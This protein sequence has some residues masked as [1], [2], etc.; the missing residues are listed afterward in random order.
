MPA[1]LGEMIPFVAMSASVS[2][3]FPWSCERCESMLGTIERIV[4]TTCANMQISR[5][6]Q[7]RHEIAP[8]RVT[9]ISDAVWVALQGDEFLWVDDRHFEDY[10][11]YYSGERIGIHA[12]EH[13]RWKIDLQV[14]GGLL[15][16]LSSENDSQ[17]VRQKT[18][19]PTNIYLK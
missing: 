17:P 11:S 9:Y 15:I 10:F 7:C 4:L 2:E 13:K 8:P 3:V 1:S 5:R 19:N 14:G 18:W 16:V 12:T 6:C